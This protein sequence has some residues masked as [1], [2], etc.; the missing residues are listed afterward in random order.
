MQDAGL[1]VDE[2]EAEVDRLKQKVEHLS[3]NKARLDTLLAEAQKQAQ[4]YKV[5]WS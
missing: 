5:G 4:D 2:K 3:E 1:A